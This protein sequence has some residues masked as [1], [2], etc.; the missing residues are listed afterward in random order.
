MNCRVLLLPLLAGLGLTSAGLADEYWRSDQRVRMAQGLRDRGLFGLA[1]TYV[2]SA[3]VR[4]PAGAAVEADLVTEQIL[5]RIGAALAAGPAD[6]PA[7]KRATAA[8]EEFLAAQ[9]N[10]PRRLQI[11]FQM[12]LVP[13]AR[14]QALVRGARLGL[15]PPE[16][17]GQ[18]AEGWET[19]RRALERLLGGI[20]AAVPE[21][22]R[23]PDA[24]GAF[25]PADLQTLAASVN[26]QIAVCLAGSIEPGM[27]TSELDR[28]DAARLVLERL[29]Q[30]R[31]QTGPDSSL[32]IACEL[33]R[34]QVLRH[35]GRSAEALRLLADMPTDRLQGSNLQRYWQLRLEQAAAGEPV[36][37]LDRMIASIAASPANAP[38][39]EIAV[40]EYL[41]SRTANAQGSGVE[42]L[43]R[44][45]DRIDSRFGQA[46]GRLASRILL[47]AAGSEVDPAPSPP[48]HTQPGPSTAS[49]SFDLAWRAAEI[50]LADG[51]PDGAIAALRRAAAVAGEQAASGPAAERAAAIQS[52][53]RAH[54]R[55]A[56]LLMERQLAADAAREL[57]GI[58][59]RFPGEPS[60]A[61]VHLRACWYARKA[62]GSG[63]NELV[64][65]LLTEHLAR[66]PSDPSAGQARVWRAQELSAAGDLLA[67]I[68]EVMAIPPDSSFRAEG[69]NFAARLVPTLLSR[70]DSG[71][72]TAISNRLHASLERAAPRDL[73][74][75]ARTDAGWTA[76]VVALAGED[77]RW[78]LRTPRAVADSLAPLQLDAGSPPASISGLAVAAAAEI[79]ANGDVDRVRSALASG[80]QAGQEADF[81]LRFLALLDLPEL[82]TPPRSEL[83]GIAAGIASDFASRDLP[84]GPSGS[85][86][87][88]NAG[89][90]LMAA[91]QPDAAIA[92]ARRV[93]QAFP[94]RQ[95]MQL[96]L[97]RSLTAAPEH[98]QEAIRQWRVLTGKLRPQ[99]DAWFEAKHETARLLL[100]SGQ[101][102][103]AR[104]LLEYLQTVPPG[105]TGSP[106]A[107]RLDRLLQQCRAADH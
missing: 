12:A 13:G 36:E 1:D 10:H 67:A 81:D 14:A 43:R 38:D 31:R 75:P 104:Q 93:S 83:L 106:W 18:A 44:W 16:A 97:A 69:W 65:S 72:R 41:A 66:W 95:E 99:S 46:W 37:R 107:P 102:A 80:R 59:Q 84:D 26:F 90:V 71:D 15:L 79:L 51:D 103:T 47:R 101:A 20:A 85:G 57:A 54:V 58:A 63:R 8:G 25:S 98:R 56:E 55:C 23:R 49:N 74:S 64:A 50:A 87:C 96:L 28:I 9:P 21:A 94:Q 39:T 89:Q 33:L 42:D 91:G 105:W 5:A 11:E 22:V 34:A 78:K 82:P 86:A 4:E 61:A 76:V 92:F 62:E 3:L 32:G 48:V 24:P 52:A 68:E 77:L 30:V 6:Q 88:A 7:W 45:A 19:G 17:N 60:S 29:E 73:A 100:E 70:T 53:L 2:A 40:L 35:T 27:P